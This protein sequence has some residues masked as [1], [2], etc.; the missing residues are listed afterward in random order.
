M[1]FK[2]GDKASVKL[3]KSDSA[4]EILDSDGQVIDS[5][6][7]DGYC[8]FTMPSGSVTV[9]EGTYVPPETSETTSAETT[10]AVTTETEKVTTAAQTEEV[11][12]SAE[13]ISTVEQTEV[14]ETDTIEATEVETTEA[15]GEETT[16]E[17]KKGGM[18][19]VWAVTVVICVIAGIIATVVVIVHSRRKNTN[20]G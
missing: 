15:S 11:T 8:Y 14:T 16:E 10:E 18:P 19:I 9:R 20:E 13:E 5:E 4:V 3:M 12:T 7:K 6:I 2:A 17:T 1:Y